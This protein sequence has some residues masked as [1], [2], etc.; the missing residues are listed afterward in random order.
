MAENGRTK[1]DSERRWLIIISGI[2]GFVSFTLG[3]LLSEVLKAP[4]CFTPND[5]ILPIIFIIISPIIT[6]SS[7]AYFW[8]GKRDLSILFLIILSLLSLGSCFILFL[9]A[10]GLVY[11]SPM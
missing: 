9:L 3:A 5:L 8:S 11:C 1:I 2:S 6:I 10:G 7:W 4:E